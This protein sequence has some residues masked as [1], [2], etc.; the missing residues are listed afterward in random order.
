MALPQQPVPTP[1]PSGDLPNPE[2]PENTDADPV[3]VG[4][5][6]D[7]KFSQADIDRSVKARLEREK[8][9]HKKALD[10]YVHVNAQLKEEVET[11]GSLVSRY[12]SAVEKIIGEQLKDLTPQITELLSKLDPLDQLE[13]LEKNAGKGTPANR[14]PV[15]PVPGAFT[16]TEITQDEAVRRKAKQMGITL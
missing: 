5:E 8:A 9:A 14:K 11:S 3:N 12:Q 16:P 13:W 2:D 6:G 4:A 10:Q 15:P 7:L 1:S